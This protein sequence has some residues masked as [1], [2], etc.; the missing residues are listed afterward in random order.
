ME[1]PRGVRW[2]SNRRSAAGTSVALLEDDAAG[3]RPDSEEESMLQVTAAA[4]EYLSDRLPEEGKDLCFVLVPMPTGQFALRLKGAEADDAIV[5]HGGDVVLAMAPRVAREL[6]GWLLDLETHPAGGSA[7]VLL[8][9]P[10]AR[11]N[12]R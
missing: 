7:L 10:D 6:S 12:G 11:G 5:R 2:R 8:R 4:R 1:A 9:A 3:D